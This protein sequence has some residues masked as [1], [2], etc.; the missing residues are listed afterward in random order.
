[1]LSIVPQETL[2]GPRLFSIHICDF[3]YQTEAPLEI[4]DYAIDGA[5]FVF[6]FQL[7][8]ILLIFK[9]KSNEILECHLMMSLKSAVN[10]D[11]HAE[12]HL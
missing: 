4:A 2:L 5:V 7:Q 6:S 12:R 9:N 10:F 1:M 8:E 3:L 11:C